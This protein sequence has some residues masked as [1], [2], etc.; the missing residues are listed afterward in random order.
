MA[1][2]LKKGYKLVRSQ[3]TKGTPEKGNNKGPDGAR[4]G[5]CTS[6]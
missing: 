2:A 6:F 5:D 3:G 4:P 1:A